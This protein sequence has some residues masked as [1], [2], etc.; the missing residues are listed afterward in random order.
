MNLQERIKKIR[1]ELCLSP[2]A[3]AKELTKNGYKITDRTIYGYEKGRRQPSI[4]YF[5]GLTNIYGINPYWILTEKGEMFFNSSDKNNYKIPENLDFS[6]I[7][8]IPLVDLYASAGYGALIED[9]Q[10]T[11]DFCAFAKKWL[12][13]NVSAPANELVLFTVNGDSMESPNSRIKDGCLILI[14]KS[15][16]ELK[17]DG[18]YV[19][20]IDDS[21]Y[22]K[23]LQLLPGKKVRVKSDN[24]L[25]DPFDVSLLDDTLRIVGK[26]VWA[27]SKIDTLK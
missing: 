15:I 17:N 25:Y 1:I 4:S 23:R 18:V 14:D 27:G 2:D 19:I 12:F 13:E 6:S 7:V 24:P 26:V 22:V 5:A 21:L 8:F 20:S 3:L 9:I 16:N 11:K 10:M